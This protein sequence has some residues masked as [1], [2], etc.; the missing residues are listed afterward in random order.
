MLL[1]SLVLLSPLLTMIQNSYSQTPNYLKLV[2]VSSK[3]PLLAKYPKF[4]RCLIQHEFKF[5]QLL[6][7]SLLDNIW[8]LWAPFQIY[9]INTKNVPQE[10][11]LD[12]LIF[13]RWR[14]QGNEKRIFSLENSVISEQRRRSHNRYIMFN[15]KW[16]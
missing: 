11:W 7:C 4:L 2:F 1:L 15:N 3:S 8:C 9:S 12:E 5:L 13:E 16:A 14:K 6:S 10:M